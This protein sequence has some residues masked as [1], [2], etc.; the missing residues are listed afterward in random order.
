MP[1]KLPEKEKISF[2]FVP[3][4]SSRRIRL[5]GVFEYYSFSDEK[6]TRNLT[7][8]IKIKIKVNQ[9]FRFT[10]AKMRANKIRKFG[11]LKKETDKGQRKRERVL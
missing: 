4:Y 11:Y 9:K 6:K 3:Y 1:K 5:V 10:Y 8:K 2:V 7:K